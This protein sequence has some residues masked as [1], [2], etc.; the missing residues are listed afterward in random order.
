MG[1]IMTRVW[2]FS[3]CVSDLAGG[4]TR[5]DHFSNIRFM[6]WNCSKYRAAI[7]VRLMG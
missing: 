2:V 1:N 3:Q 7:Y 6:G 4:K 5:E